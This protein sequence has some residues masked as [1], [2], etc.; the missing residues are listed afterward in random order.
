MKANKR[1]FSCKQ[2][3]NEVI[4]KNAIVCVFSFLNLGL[5][6]WVTEVLY[7]ISDTSNVDF[8]EYGRCV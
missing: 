5:L 7:I 4:V 1:R 3:V 6:I 8:V 2:I